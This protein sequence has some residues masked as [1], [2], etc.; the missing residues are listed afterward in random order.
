MNDIKQ[1][2]QKAMD[3]LN[4]SVHEALDKK[5]RLGQY[6][7]VWRDGK[8]VHLSGDELIQKKQK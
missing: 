6:A 4:Q 7:V 2:A 3:A 8:I 5:R 1:H